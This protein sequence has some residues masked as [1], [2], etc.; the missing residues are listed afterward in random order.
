MESLVDKYKPIKGLDVVYRQWPQNTTT[1]P[2]IWCSV[3]LCDGNQALPVPMT[4]SQ[5]LEF[6]AALV[7]CGLKEIE[8]GFPSASATDYNFVRHL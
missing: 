2:P 8:V 3:D 1:K 7:K 4:I 5:K 6:F